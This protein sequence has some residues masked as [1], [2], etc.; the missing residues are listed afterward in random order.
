MTNLV[1]F[2]AYFTV[3]PKGISPAQAGPRGVEVTL[4]DVRWR[5][6]RHTAALGRQQSGHLDTRLETCEDRNDSECTEQHA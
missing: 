6:I 2:P 5:H 4:Q 1:V 3:E